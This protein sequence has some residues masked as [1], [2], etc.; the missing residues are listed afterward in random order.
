MPPG[1]R[2]KAVLISDDSFAALVLAFKQ[3]PK[4]LAY[5]EETRKLWGRSL[6][7]AARPALLGSRS[8]Q[9][10]RPSLVQAFFDGLADKPGKSAACYS[11]I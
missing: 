4:F 5:A 1:E 8:L 11:A 7:F 10:I 6:D 3:S 9:E 2:P